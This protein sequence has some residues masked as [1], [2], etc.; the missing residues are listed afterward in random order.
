[1]RK[2]TYPRVAVVKKAVTGTLSAFFTLLITTSAFSADFVVNTAKASYYVGSSPAA[3]N[4]NTVSEIICTNSI[5]EF[6]K[7]A[8]LSTDAEMI[9]VST[10]KYMDV[11]GSFISMQNPVPVGS[12]S[13]LDLSKPIPLIKADVYHESEPIFLRLTDD[14]QNVDTTVAETIL[15][16]L[17]SHGI[18]ETE[19]LLLTE[20]GPNTG[21]FVGYI[22]SVTEPAVDR[23]GSFSVY[24]NS[25]I[26]ATYEDKCGPNGTGINTVVAATALVDPFGVVFDSSSGLPVDGATVTLVNAAT[27]QPAAVYG[28][29]GVSSYPSTVTTGGTT[30]DSSGVVYTFPPGGYRFPFISAGRYRLDVVPPPAYRAPSV[31]STA[32]ILNLGP[33]A[34][35]EPGSRGEEFYINPGP[36]IHIDLPVDPIRT[37]LY[38]TKTASKDTVAI[39]DFLQYKITVENTADIDI[40]G[41]LVNDRLP[42]GFRYRKGSTKIDG[43]ASADPSHSTDGRTLTFNLGTLVSHKTADI[44]Y[45]VE[46]AAG[47]KIGKAINL[48]AATGSGGAVSNTARAEVLVKED[49]FGSKTIIMGRIFPRGCG[50]SQDSDGVSGVRIYLEDGTYAVTDKKGMYHFEGVKPGSHVVQLDLETI[51]EDYELTSCEENDRFAGTPYS[52][53]VD[54]QGGTMWRADF[55]AVPKPKAPPLPPVEINGSVGIELRSILKTVEGRGEPAGRPDVDYELS[56]HVGSVPVSN[57]RI[58]IILPEGVEYKKGSSNLGDS[59][60]PDP[61]IMENVLTYRLKEEKEGWEGKVRFSANVAQD[62]KDGD[63]TAKAILTFDSQTAKNQRTPLLE[64]ILR[65]KSVEERKANPDA[66]LRPHFD[67]IKAELKKED[68]DVLD[69]IISDLK[70]VNV[71]EIYVTGHTDSTRIAP[72]SRH[73]FA[74]NYAL[75]KARAK[76]VADYIAGGLGLSPSQVIA[77]GKGPDEPVE[78]NIT[79]AGRARNR[80]V[81]LRVVSE[82]VIKL[83]EI[84]NEK[85]K[86]GL[87]EVEI[88]AVKVVEISSAEKEREEKIKARTM[89]EFDSAWLDKSEPGLAFVWPYDGFHPPIPSVKIAVKHDPGKKLRLLMN[90]EEVDPLY[91]D[92]TKKRSDNQVAVS[93]WIGIHV[94]DGDNLFE[95]VEYSQDGNEEN[96]IG[97]TI[98][99]STPPVKAELVPEQSRLTADGKT[100][101]VIAVRLTDK[102]GH[103]AREG[104]IGEYKVSPPYLPFQKFEDLQNDP[105]TMSKSERLKYV[106]GEDGIALIELQPT[107]D[108]GEA[109]L[110]FNLVSGENE[111]RTWLTPGERDWILV[112]LAEGTVGYNTVNGNMESLGDSGADDKYYDD[113]RIAFFAKGMIKGKWLLTMAYDSEKKGVKKNDSL[114][115]IIDPDKYYTL[116]GDATQQGYDVASAR[117]L[118]LKIE[119]D[120]FYALFGDFETGLN[121]TEL[122]RYSRNLNGFKSVMKGDKFDFNVFVSDTNQAFIKDEIRGDGTSGLYRLSRKNIVLNSESVTIE[123]R[124]RFR[125]EEIISSITLSRHIDYNIDYDAGTIYFKSPIYSRDENFNPVYIVVN[126]ESFDPS[127]MSYNYGGRGAVRFIDNKLEVGATRI[128]EGRIGGDGDLTGIDAKLKL[129]DK[130]DVRAEFAQTDTDFNNVS[131]NG[132]AYLAEVSRRSEKLDGK[133]YVREQESEFGL[134]QQNGSESGT[135]KIGFN[136]TY[137]LNEKVSFNTEAFRQY[138]L[139]TDAVRDMAD[140]QARY[141][142]KQYEVHGGL[143]HAEDTL[144]D[145]D[146][147]NSEQ[148]TAGGSYRMLNDR[149][150]LRLE[151]DQSLFSNNENADYPTRTTIGADY[152]LNETAALFAAQEF[153]QGETEDTETTRIG[154]KA[155]P[156]SGGQISSSLEQQYTENGARVFAV[157]G[158]KQTWQ[159]TNKWSVDA[160]LDRSSTLK[161]PG[162]DSFNTNVPAASGGSDFTAVSM[163]ATYKEEKWSWTGRIE[164]RDSENE[165]KVGIFTG[166]YGEVK[167]GIGLAAAL[168]AFKTESSSGTNKTSGDLRFSLAYRPKETKWIVLDRLDYIFDEQKGAGF[169][170]DNWRIINNMNANFKPDRKTQISLQYGAK[171]VNDTIEEIDYSGYTDLMG[172][173][174]RYDITKKWDIGIRG[175]ALHSWDVDQFKYGTGASIGYNFVKNVWVSAG[176]NFTG[177]RDKDF[178]KADFTA[179]GP[180]VKF[181]MKFDQGTAKDAVKWFSGQ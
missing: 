30:S 62:G 58:S 26:M 118:Y 48:A 120:K 99:Y 98:H 137:R 114:Y 139:A 45:V 121:V 86:S 17:E 158:L 173:E 56:L 65:R 8:P 105:L 88:K 23:N 104:V 51:P 91:L 100:P 54:L 77:E 27:G 134:G 110:K 10:T 170:Y 21:V 117:A 3:C 46:I 35:V 24:E 19:T 111:V 13:A 80:R 181:R 31:V 147:N 18:G 157:N 113:G 16:T 128:H 34:I 149:L 64:N 145:G 133:L 85:D 112:G 123:T 70:K 43:A 4:S 49:L 132:S 103:P 179:E 59:A 143:R 95:A 66:I 67:V 115:G 167:D 94:K 152:K 101:P 28:D 89:P 96:R 36:A 151:H 135:R 176:Y 159:V 125:S 33:F 180:F 106:V 122:S 168:Q 12:T 25:Q 74:D 109:T 82:N 177:F 171:Y 39:G 68:T 14:D 102:E 163:G 178:S 175:S 161:H 155:S 41:I 165:D 38:V 75:S 136:G 129:D 71:L 81:E 127:D 174:G 72:R 166:A 40:D 154:L 2:K 93:L 57:L 76:S 124:D 1:M 140:A 90:G 141:N 172:L 15:L 78:S 47:A 61:E 162:N 63:L 116:Y 79:A 83:S 160:G 107:S 20:T 97:R 108:T 138:N 60:L 156:W 153:T 32:D 53:F 148:V 169:D 130:T 5:L 42:L 22:Q 87:K 84:K 164:T 92:G 6:L 144:G 52:Q 11:P 55:Y 29:D 142:E 9:S 131:S 44:T 119:R 69:G 126:Y 150:I 73:I 37:W 146:V 7:Y 50:D